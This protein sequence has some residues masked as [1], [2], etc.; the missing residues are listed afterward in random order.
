MVGFPI[1]SK[2]FFKSNS[3]GNSKYQKLDQSK[4][5]RKDFFFIIMIIFG[6]VSIWRTKIPLNYHP[7][8][9]LITSVSSTKEV[10]KWTSKPN[11]QSHCFKCLFNYA[12]YIDG[13][14][15]LLEMIWILMT[16][17]Q[18]H[19]ILEYR[20]VRYYDCPMVLVMV[21]FKAT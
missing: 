17:F 20:L 9:G 16:I 15:S 8:F 2:Y 12:L 5:F 18:I 6:I 7:L 10:R 3:N 11:W 1:K 4:K 21:M 14:L 19:I 13:I